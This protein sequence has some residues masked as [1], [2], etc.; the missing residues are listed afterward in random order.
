LLKQVAKGAKLLIRK[1]IDKDAPGLAIKI[2][3]ELERSGKSIS[4]ICKAIGISRTYWYQLMTND[5]VMSVV[6]LRAIEREL[7]VDFE[8]EI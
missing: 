5:S 7:N 1:I 4:S 8:I 3:I 2:E 6:L